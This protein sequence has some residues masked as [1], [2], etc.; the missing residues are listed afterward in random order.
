MV[1]SVLE[2]TKFTT[3]STFMDKACKIKPIER[4]SELIF[5]IRIKKH[6]DICKKNDLCIPAVLKKKM[7]YIIYSIIKL[8]TNG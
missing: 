7:I 3:K 4:R 5:K 8:Q 1:I 2:Q 6:L